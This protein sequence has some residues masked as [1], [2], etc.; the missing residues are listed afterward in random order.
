MKIN[1]GNEA[2]DLSLENL[3]SIGNTSKWVN[4]PWEIA[5]RHPD[6]LNALAEQYGLDGHMTEATYS[7]IASEATLTLDGVEDIT[8]EYGTEN[9]E[10][11]KED[12]IMSNNNINNNNA[13]V[14][15]AEATPNFTEAIHD[16]AQN[17]AKNVGATVINSTERLKG[18]L[19]DTNKEYVDDN[20]Q[21]INI[22][23]AGFAGVLSVLDTLT[24]YSGLKTDIEEILQ[25]GLDK[26]GRHD[27]FRMANKCRQL[28]DEEIQW[29]SASADE[30]S[31][32]TCMTLKALNEECRGKSIIEAGV[33]G[34]LWIAKRI[35]RKFSKI[36]NGLASRE[37]IIGTITKGFGAF[38]GFF[39]SIG[40]VALSAAKFGFSFVIAGIIKAGVF[41]KSC[42]DSI[43]NKIK[44]WK[45]DKL[46]AFMAEDDFEDDDLLDEENDDFLEEEE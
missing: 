33:A 3:F 9:D 25:E 45:N 6:F 27:L 11:E 28:I 43:L 15:N 40:N 35:H 46:G 24:G 26:G 12:I 22:I 30:E 38:V 8:I 29:L 2:I 37:D 17:L 7:M 31:I 41:I 32:K 10:E 16:I 42:L 34:L 14:N 20:E 18:K 13:T 36:Y 1:I 21:S 5:S 19:Y 39:V 44:Q 4:I 23:K